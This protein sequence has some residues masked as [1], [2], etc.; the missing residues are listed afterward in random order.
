MCR[1]CPSHWSAQARPTC[2]TDA[3]IS[4][5]QVYERKGY[6]YAIFKDSTANRYKLYRANYATTNLYDA[7]TRAEVLTLT[8]GALHREP[9]DL[10]DRQD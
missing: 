6:A 7:V 4:C 2:S 3:F 5:A 9:A 10:R 1:S 8:N